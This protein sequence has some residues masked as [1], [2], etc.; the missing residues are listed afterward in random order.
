MDTNYKSMANVIRIKSWRKAIP[1]VLDDRLTVL[2]IQRQPIFHNVN[3]EYVEDQSESD[4][5]IRMAEQFPKPMMLSSLILLQF[6][7]YAACYEAMTELKLNHLPCHENNLKFTKRELRSKINLMET[8]AP[9][10]YRDDKPT[11]IESI[12]RLH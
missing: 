12:E 9:L 1:V 11:K 2:K 4:L 3:N 6:N 10:R 7:S 8:G 5:L